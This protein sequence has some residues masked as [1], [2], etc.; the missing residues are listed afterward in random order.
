MLRIL[1]FKFFLIKTV[2]MLNGLIFISIMRFKCTPVVYFFKGP[3]F[4]SLRKVSKLLVFS[5]LINI[6]QT[7]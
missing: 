5:F 2:L 3:L 7:H 1:F 4:L 6:Y